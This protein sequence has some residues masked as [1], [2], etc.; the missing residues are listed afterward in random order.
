MGDAVHTAH[1]AIGSGTKLAHRRRDRAGAAVQGSRRRRRGADRRSAE[2][3]PGRCAASTCCACR[4]RPGTR[5]SGSR[6]WASAMPTRLPPEQFMYSMLTRS[7][8]ISHENLRLRDADW[9]EGYERWFARK[10]RARRGRRHEAAAADVHAVHG[11]RRDAEEPRR[12]LADGAVLGVD[13]VPGDFHLVHLGARA[14]GGAGLVFAEMTCVSADA[15][16]TPGCP[17]LW[18]DAQRAPGGASSTSCTRTATRRSA[19]RS[20]M[21]G[22]KGSTRVA[23]GRRRPAAG[24][25]QLAADGGV[26]RCRTWPACARCRAR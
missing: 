15:R 14:L 17:G 18:N 22:A 20:A 23:L 4:T 13:G 3:L 24:R 21:P 7:Q 25:R 26:A 12:G 1:F 6:R 5:W 16:I 2:A 11:A 10:R 8:R 19:C 9:L